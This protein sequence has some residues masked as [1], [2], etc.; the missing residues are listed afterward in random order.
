MEQSDS[1]Q[2]GDIRTQ[3]RKSTHRGMERNCW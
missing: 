2:K 1:G 3:M